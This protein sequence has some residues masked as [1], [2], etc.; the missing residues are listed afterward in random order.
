MLSR[1]EATQVTVDQVKTTP[2]EA[3]A[4]LNVV[5]IRV[6][7]NVDK[8]QHDG[9]HEVGDEVVLAT[10][11]FHINKYLAKKIWHHWVGPDHIA[12][13]TFPLA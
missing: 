10:H 12:Q 5:Q 6:Q 13:V 9:K 11:N 7:A 1:I 3:H 8:S 2:E 4:K